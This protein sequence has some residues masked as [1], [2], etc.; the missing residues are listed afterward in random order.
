MAKKKYTNAERKA[1][2]SG[3]G[4]RIAHDGKAIK[5]E[6]AT[7]RDSFTAGYKSGGKVIAKRPR[8]YPKLKK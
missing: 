3:M 7:I 1:Y 4:Y 8:K 5:F 2:Y 6:N